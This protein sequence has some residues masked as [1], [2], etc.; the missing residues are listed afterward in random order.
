MILYT[1]WMKFGREV[2]TVSQLLNTTSSTSDTAL[3]STMSVTSLIVSAR[4]KSVGL[5]REEELKGIFFPLNGMKRLVGIVEY[6]SVISDSRSPASPFASDD[7]AALLEVRAAGA[8][9][10]VGAWEASAA[11]LSLFAALVVAEDAFL[12]C[13]V[14]DSVAFDV[15]SEVVE[16]SFALSTSIVSLWPSWGFGEGDEGA[17]ASPSTSRFFEVR[18]AA[19][20]PRPERL[21][22]EEV[23]SSSADS[24]APLFLAFFFSGG[25]AS[26]ILA[27]G[28]RGRG[29]CVCLGR[30]E[31]SGDR[32]SNRRPNLVSP[33]PEC[34]QE[35]TANTINPSTMDC[36]NVIF[37]HHS[38]H[39]QT[40]PKPGLQIRLL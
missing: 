21:E 40:R 14:D 3:S 20:A 38:G 19:I 10:L 29:G 17:D 26:L 31:R 5:D 35:H 25:E 1:S 2:A 18:L 22:P 12:A 23:S 36:T 39:A 8:D 11:L 33:E 34:L 24:V 32:G 30:T 6:F 13:V 4:S 27:G 15:G 16:V 7:G 37:C 9:D 28:A